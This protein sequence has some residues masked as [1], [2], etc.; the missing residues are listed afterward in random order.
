[1]RAVFL[2]RFP[3]FKIVCAPT[4]S[5]ADIFWWSPEMRTG[6]WAALDIAQIPPVFGI[7]RCISVKK[8]WKQKTAEHHKNIKTFV[9]GQIILSL[10]QQKH[11]KGGQ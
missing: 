6:E 5:E 1:M 11:Q 10:A 7:R 4:A 3:E 9:T 8:E 2:H